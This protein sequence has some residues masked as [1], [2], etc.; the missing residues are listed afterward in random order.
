VEEIL[1]ASFVFYRRR[2]WACLLAMAVVQL[3]VTVVN[4]LVSEAAWRRIELA[5]TDAVLL[6][7]GLTYTLVVVLPT[8]FLSLA[9][10]HVS[11]GA[12]TCIVGRACGGVH[13]GVGEAYAWA[14]RRM[15]PLL[16]ASLLVAA[17]SIFGFF[18]FVVPGVLMFLVSFAVVPA[19]VLEDRGVI[20][21]VR[22]SY[23]L[24]TGSLGRV[25]AVRLL[26]ALFLVV[27]M[28]VG[29]FLAT[30]LGIPDEARFLAA[31]VFTLLAAPVDAI[32]TVL[33]YYDLRV[34]REGLDL[35]RMEEELAP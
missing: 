20:D 5:G 24:A 25:T 8:A 6:T 14:F 13:V 33:L 9:A 32:S 18:F 19:V 4:T 12:L 28:A 31:Q 27:T 35:R 15:L 22:R 30:S 2:F 21:S 29:M 26:I 17:G 10:T 11:T 3:P 7:E 16:G 34:R 23:T 1:D